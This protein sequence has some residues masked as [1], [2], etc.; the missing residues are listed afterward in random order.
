MG[1][2]SSS[3]KNAGAWP[4]LSGG[5][6]PY[7]RRLEI[8]AGAPALRLRQTMTA[9]WGRTGRRLERVAG[10]PAGILAGMPAGMK[11]MASFIRRPG[12]KKAG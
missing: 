8:G 2:P 6:G 3:E 1:L 9:E 11:D 4:E 5:I 7:A 12:M 10:K